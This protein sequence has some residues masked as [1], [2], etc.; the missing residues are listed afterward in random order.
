MSKGDDGKSAFPFEVRHL[1]GT[2]TYSYGMTLRDYFAGQ[3]LAG[4]LASPASPRINDLAVHDPKSYALGAYLWADA[5]I[6]ERD[7]ADYPDEVS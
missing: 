4:M 2:V 6:A 5:M 1:D 7:K 3:A